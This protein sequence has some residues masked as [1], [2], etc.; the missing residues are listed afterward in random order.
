MSNSGTAICEI[1]HLMLIAV[2]PIA[3]Q[4]KF[5]NEVHDFC[6]LYQNVWIKLIWQVK[7]IFKTPM[8]VCREISAGLYLNSLSEGTYFLFGTMQHLSLWRLIQWW[9]GPVAPWVTDDLKRSWVQLPRHSYVITQ[10][11]EQTPA[12]GGKEFPQ[13]LPRLKWWKGPMNTPTVLCPQGEQWEEPW[14]VTIISGL[15]I[16]LGHPSSHWGKNRV[17]AICRF[18]YTAGRNKKP[19]VTTYK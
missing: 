9:S 16:N 14:A 7:F 3:S 18:W 5:R 4:H 1:S 13:E 15:E 17:L 12:M 8:L 2:S 6:M 19:C 10:A 11:T